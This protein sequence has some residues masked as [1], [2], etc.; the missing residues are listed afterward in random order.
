MLEAPTETELWFA[1]D[2]LIGSEDTRVN[3]PEELTRVP[4][5][6]G[7]ASRVTLFQLVILSLRLTRA[8]MVVLG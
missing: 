6:G 4:D 3:C 2:E 7:R 1:D 5:E 8:R